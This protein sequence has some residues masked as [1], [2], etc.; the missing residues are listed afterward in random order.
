MSFISSSNGSG[1]LAGYFLVDDENCV[2]ETATIPADHANVVTKADGTKY[3]P[4]GTIIDNK[5]ILYEDIDVTNGDAPGSIVTKGTVCGDKL[6]STPN[7]DGIVVVE[8]SA[9]VERPY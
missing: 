3:V 8:Q 5:G 1:F 7:I 6:E 2:R 9:T 4:A